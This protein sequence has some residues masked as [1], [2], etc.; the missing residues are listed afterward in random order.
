MISKAPIIEASVGGVT[1]RF[2]VNTGSQVSTIT[3]TFYHTHLA[4]NK[5]HLQNPKNW[6]TIR[7]ANGLTVPYV[8]YLELGI[9]LC[10]LVVPKRGVLVVKDSEERKGDVWPAWN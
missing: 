1:T 6:L 3:E 4:Q 2:L 8:G 7:A 9:E 5:N 10:G